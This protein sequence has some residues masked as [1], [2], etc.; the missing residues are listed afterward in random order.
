L[1]QH[2][3]AARPI[4]HQ[5]ES[6]N[7]HLSIVFAALAPSRLIKDRIGWSIKKVRPHHPLLPHHRHPRRQPDAHRPR[8]QGLGKVDLP[9]I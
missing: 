8:P 4:Y 6:I 3:L 9:V 5:C 2:D 7:A 1:S